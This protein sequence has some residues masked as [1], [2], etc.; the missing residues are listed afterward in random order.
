M[1][2]QRCISHNYPVNSVFSG[3]GAL[4]DLQEM[5]SGAQIG[6]E[7][8]AQEFNCY[9]CLSIRERKRHELQFCHQ[10]TFRCHQLR[11]LP[12]G[13][14]MIDNSESKVNK[15]ASQS[16]ECCFEWN[17]NAYFF[18][19]IVPLLQLNNRRWCRDSYNGGDCNIKCQDLLNDN[20]KASI[21]CAKLRQE[22]TGFRDWPTFEKR[23]KPMRLPNIRDCNWETIFCTIRVIFYCGR[24]MW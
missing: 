18:Q 17:W 24:L 22:T 14:T 2:G 11:N 19:T 6:G 13:F 8:S 15:P 1:V 10:N 16:V 20:L 5:W 3:C 21:T 4:K 9:L 12:G 23:C 7:W